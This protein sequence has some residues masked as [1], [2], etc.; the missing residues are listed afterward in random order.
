MWRAC[1]VCL[2]LDM[3]LLSLFPS[4]FTR[5]PPPLLQMGRTSNLLLG[6]ALALF[7]GSASGQDSCVQ[8]SN[9]L[10]EPVCPCDAGSEFTFQIEGETTVAANKVRDD[11]FFR[12]AL[13]IACGV[14]GL[15][16]GRGAGAVQV[17]AGYASP[18]SCCGSRCDEWRSFTV[19]F[20][21]GSLCHINIFHMDRK[22]YSN[23]TNQRLT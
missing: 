14:C 3:P 4:P 9:A 6:G 12:R 21:S 8:V 17:I 22:I 18:Q 19:F 13:P 20:R 11:V 7:L 15:K 23:C 10:F 1:G 2:D 5:P 16:M